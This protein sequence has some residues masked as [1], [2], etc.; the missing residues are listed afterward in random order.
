[1]TKIKLGDIAQ[2]RIG[3][4]KGVV[5][6]ETDWLYANRRLLL[7]EI[8]TNKRPIR[9][10]GKY[11]FD[12]DDLILV[13]KGAY[14]A[15]PE[16]VYPFKLGDWARDHITRLSGKIVGKTVW[17]NG[18]VRF[19]IQPPTLHEGKPVDDVSIEAG[20]LELIDAPADDK[21][22]PAPAKKDRPGGPM[23]DPTPAR[24]TV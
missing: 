7:E 17:L 21:V 15:K 18:C 11:G 3:K 22:E 24:D 12:E 23:R 20:K 9:L 13:K 1:M 19:A 5:M 10:G 6:A 8:G 2:D 14:K 4:F 16:I